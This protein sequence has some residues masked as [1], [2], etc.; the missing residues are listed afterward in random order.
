MAGVQAAT[1]TTG[2]A[3]GPHAVW[4]LCAPRNQPRRVFE[5][6]CY[7]TAAC[8]GCGEDCTWMGSQSF[9]DSA[10][11]PVLEGLLLDVGCRCRPPRTEET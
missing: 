10:G 8:P 7:Y 3:D 11:M 6:I 9:V 4:E 1:D 2:I 5:R